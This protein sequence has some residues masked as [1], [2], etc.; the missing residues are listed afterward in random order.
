M[1][2]STSVAREYLEQVAA[3]TL[4]Q[5]CV[6]LTLML[7]L[8]SPT[9]VSSN[10]SPVPSRPKAHCVFTTVR[11]SAALSTQRQATSIIAI[12]NESYHHRH[13]LIHVAL[14]PAH[15]HFLLR[16]ALHTVCVQTIT[17]PRLGWSA[18][19]SNM[20]LSVDG[21]SVQKVLGLNQ[22]SAILMIYGHQDPGSMNTMA[23]GQ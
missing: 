16:A 21:L 18:V 10:L 19:S 23:R 8:M 1:L 2:H 22:D 12:D 3:D 7:L 14:M 15:L 17:P 4:G 9:Q 11:F 6:S 20:T 5:G 13:S